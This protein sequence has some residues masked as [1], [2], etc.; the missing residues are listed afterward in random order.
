MKSTLIFF[1]IA[2]VLIYFLLSFRIFIALILAMVVVFWL[3]PE[4]VKIWFDEMR[5][6]VGKCRNLSRNFTTEKQYPI[7]IGQENIY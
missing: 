2:A 7:I 6:Y 4:K 3:K 1:L 5:G